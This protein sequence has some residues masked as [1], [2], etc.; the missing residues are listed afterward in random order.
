M[1]SKLSQHGFSYALILIWVVLWL[2]GRR[3]DLIEQFAGKGFDVIGHEYY[4]FATSLLLHKGVLHMLANAAAL[5]WVGVYLEPQFNSAK[6]CLFAIITAIQAQFLFSMIYRNSASMVGG[7]PIVFTLLGLIL[8]LNIMEKP[9]LKFELGTWYGNWIVGYVI[10]SNLPILRND[11]SIL[12]IHGISLVL[13]MLYGG[14]AI[15]FHL[16]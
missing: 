14:I 10:L 6:L 16:F 7:S 13:G 12:A 4:R 9:A 2:I 1:M 8:L 3:N 15:G 11:I 5:Y